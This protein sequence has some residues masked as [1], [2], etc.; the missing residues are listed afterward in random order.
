MQPLKADLR[1]R[2]AVLQDIPWLY[3]LMEE[4]YRDRHFGDR[5]STSVLLGMLREAVTQQT[6]TR[7]YANQVREHVR[8]QLW[9]A[10]VFT[11]NK[12]EGVGFL[13]VLYTQEGVEIYLGS[14]KKAFRKTNTARQLG[15]HV[16]RS[17]KEG[18]KIYTWCFE[19]SSWAIHGYLNDPLYPFVIE[20][21]ILHPSGV[22]LICLSRQVVQTSWAHS[23]INHS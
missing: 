17:L 10:D 18:T 19:H 1:I 9:V 21:T 15:Y 22:R 20:K 12:T 16:Y 11:K 7:V 4:G 14:V 2:L 3:A 8:C 13:L 6:H 23:L 5:P